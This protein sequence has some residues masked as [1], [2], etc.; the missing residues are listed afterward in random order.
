MRIDPP[1]DLVKD[2]LTEQVTTLEVPSPPVDRLVS[3]GRRRLLRR[4]RVAAIS[5]AG[6]VA[7]V[8]FAMSVPSSLEPPRERIAPTTQEPSPTVQPQSIDELPTGAAPAIPYVVGS[9]LQTA[10][11]S[12][13]MEL[14]YPKVVTGG[15]VSVVYGGNVETGLSVYLIDGSDSTGT[16]HLRLLTDEAAGQPVVSTDGRLVAWPAGDEGAQGAGADRTLV[17]LWSVDTGQLLENPVSFPFEPTCC[18]NPFVLLGV[19]SDGR[20]Y[21]TGSGKTWMAWGSLEHV[22]LVTGL[23]DGYVTAV[24]PR[25]VLVETFTK[26]AAKLELGEVAPWRFQPRLTI[27]GTRGLVSPG[28]T[29]LAYTDADGELRL[30]DL[31]SGRDVAALL[32]FDVAENT[33]TWESEESLLVEVHEEDSGSWVLARCTLD[34]ACEAAAH[35]DHR[36]GS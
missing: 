14:P 2:T 25:G 31:E 6:A 11:G 18:D 10:T 15:P 36:G 32:P 7:A 30:R 22:D 5:A 8:A 13:S 23:G 24:A 20:V 26:T 21:G 3:G 1:A 27:P 9:V 16:P 34:G 12:I 28:S 17:A 4:R 35:L 29:A 19:D 33:M